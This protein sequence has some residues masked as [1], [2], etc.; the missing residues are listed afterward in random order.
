MRR[1]LRFYND[2]VHRQVEERGCFH[3]VLLSS[4]MYRFFFFN[5][6]HGFVSLPDVSAFNI[7]CV[8]DISGTFCCKTDAYSIPILLRCVCWPSLRLQW[9]CRL[10]ISIKTHLGSFFVGLE[11]CSPFREAAVRKGITVVVLVRGLPRPLFPSPP[12]SAC[13]LVLAFSHRDVLSFLLLD[14]E[15]LP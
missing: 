7:N 6:L 15:S 1:F 4:C 3:V 13:C 12:C 10:G 5:L 8:C 2:I 9:Q 11:K 14:R